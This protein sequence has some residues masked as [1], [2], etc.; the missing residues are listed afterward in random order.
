MPSGGMLVV[1]SAADAADVRRG[2][3]ALGL[4]DGIWDNGTITRES[5]R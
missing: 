1:V 2:A 5:P 3:L 4:R